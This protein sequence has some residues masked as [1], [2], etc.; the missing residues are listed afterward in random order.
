MNFNLIGEVLHIASCIAV[1]CVHVC[2][3]VCMCVCVCVCV[4]II[5][6]IFFLSELKQ[7]VCYANITVNSQCTCVH[8]LVGK[9][10]TQQSSSVAYAHAHSSKLL[11]IDSYVHYI[12]YV[13]SYDMICLLAELYTV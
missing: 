13:M 4:H 10:M 6:S 12:I 8:W 7:L 9:H 3:C 2:V 1:V 5:C 11:L